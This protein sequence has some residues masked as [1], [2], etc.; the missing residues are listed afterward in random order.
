MS[1]DLAIARIRAYR[2]VMGWSVLKFATE[3][4]MGESTIRKMDREDWSPTADTL[5]K[6]E[7]VVPPDFQPPAE[8][9]GPP[10]ADEAA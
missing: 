10:A 1:I 5:R 4:G 7:A 9:P 6:L 2:R 3:A 8:Q